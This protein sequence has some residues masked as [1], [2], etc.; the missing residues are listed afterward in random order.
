MPTSDIHA[1]TAV[2]SKGVSHVQS[3]ISSAVTSLA[4]DVNTLL[5]VNCSI[6]FKD[7]CVG[8]LQKYSC[9]E[10]PINFSQLVPDAIQ[11]PLQ[12]QL[13]QLND[14]SSLASPFF[15]R[16]FLISSTIFVS[17]L[18]V[19]GVL[20]NPGLYDRWARMLQDPGLYDRWTRTQAQWIVWIVR[21]VYLSVFT[22]P[23]FLLV[24]PTVISWTLQ[25]KLRA[26]PLVSVVA[27]GD[28]PKLCLVALGFLTAL[29]VLIGFCVYRRRSS[30][31]QKSTPLKRR[32]N[33]VYE[34]PRTASESTWTLSSTG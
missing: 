21:I 32:T 17:F 4:S 31:A 11:T 29:V 26:A 6:G 3:A 25:S 34:G 19:L 1:A 13:T 7:F 27:N 20:H 14:L 15:L 23:Y 8:Y 5:P 30:D 10:L 2:I 12:K 16:N 9:I 24:V 22:I 18:V 33:G 28:A